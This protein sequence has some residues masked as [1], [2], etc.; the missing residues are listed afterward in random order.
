MAEMSQ[1]AQTAGVLD[2]AIKVRVVFVEVSA[3]TDVA[4]PYFAGAPHCGAAA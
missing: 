4:N 3:S 2:E 1:T